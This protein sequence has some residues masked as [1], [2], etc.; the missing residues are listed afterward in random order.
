LTR[1]FTLLAV[2][3]LGNSASAQRGG[4]LT[5]KV[6]DYHT[7]TGAR[8][9]LEE[10]MLLEPGHGATNISH[11]V[12]RAGI[13]HR[14]LSRFIL[15]VG[16]ARQRVSPI[17]S[18][19]PGLPDSLAAPHGVSLEE[20]GKGW[21]GKRF[22]FEFLDPGVYV[23][24]AEWWLRS[25]GHASE[26]PRIVKSNP[27]ILFVKP[28][29]GY[30]ETARRRMETDGSGYLEG[31]ELQEKLERFYDDHHDDADCT[32]MILPALE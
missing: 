25:R 18:S 7:V 28:S 6:S 5:A 31:L 30:D 12:W 20:V 26:K 16:P 29:A 27:V 32:F 23:V 14:N 10:A 1:L 3:A 21:L 15:M 22:S 8:I 11:E 24:K 13:Y 2:L 9:D 17:H 4:W 19:L